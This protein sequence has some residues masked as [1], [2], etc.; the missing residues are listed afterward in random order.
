MNRIFSERKRFIT[1]IAI[2]LI[3]VISVFAAAC[4]KPVAPDKPNDP[5]KTDAPA[6]DNTGAECD[7]TNIY[8]KLVASGKLPTLTKISEQDLYESYGIEKD[9]LKQWVFALSENYSVEAGEVAL[10]EAS[11]ESYADALVTKLQ[12]HL[13]GIRR[14]AQN[15]NPSETAKIEP[16]EV[17]RVDNYV[18]M[19]V[20]EDYGALMQIIKDNIG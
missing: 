17:T 8:D 7:L 20:G 1:T 19:V 10:F 4:S 6:T 11:D 2:V 16:V 3:T 14:V 13:D 15:Y 9:K 5:A 12:N 18:Y